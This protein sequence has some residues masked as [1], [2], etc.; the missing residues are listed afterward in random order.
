MTTFRLHQDEDPSVH[1][2]ALFEAGCDDSSPSTGK[3]GMIGLTCDRETTSAIDAISSAFENVNA[4]I[5]LAHIERI[6][7]E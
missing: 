4:T 6:S 2:D 1:L 7:L 5:P 3:A